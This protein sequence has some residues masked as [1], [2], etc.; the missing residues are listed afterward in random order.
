MEW[1]RGDK[2]VHRTEKRVN[3]KSGAEHRDGAPLLT[4]VMI[5]VM[6]FQSAFM[7]WRLNEFV[8]YNSYCTESSR[9][10]LRTQ[11]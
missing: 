9:W 1:L 5:K 7:I 2:I 11:N 10:L 6:T 3:K 4:K 8:N